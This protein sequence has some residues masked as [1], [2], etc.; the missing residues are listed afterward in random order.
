MSRLHG[1]F[2]GLF[3][4]FCLLPDFAHAQEL[5]EKPYFVTYNHYLEEPD[6]LETEVEAVHGRAADI[7][8]FVGGVTEFEYGATKWWT[9][10]LY[11]DWQHTNHQGSAF[12]GF[13]LE[14]RFRL[15]MEP[16]KINP[17]LYLEYEHISEADKVLKEIVGFDSK[18]D[19]Q[20][21]NSIA[22][23]N[24]E[25]EL[26]TRLI[27]SSDFGKWNLSENIIAEKNLGGGSWE[28]GYAAGISRAL[29]PRTGN[30]CAFC[31]GNF[32]VGVEA[33]GGAGTWR[34]L[35]FNNTS[36]YIAPTLLWVLPSETVIRFSPGWGLTDQ[37]VGT[38]FRMSV[39]QEF[40]DVGKKIGK[41]FHKH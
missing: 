33:Y 1:G 5:E 21:P 10:E 18:E 40:D 31:A 35:T 19:L 3:V 39:S 37:S 26:E 41:L 12:T 20:V 16:H 32:T 22:R 17:V 7:N 6:A 30:R 15:F 25:N 2:V 4:A 14:N 24:Y 34:N 8:N 23:H 27:L 28:F 38:L 29:G 9:S 36:Q 13:R 11:L